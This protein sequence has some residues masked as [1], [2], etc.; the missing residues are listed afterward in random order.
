[1][2][3]FESTGNIYINTYANISQVSFTCSIFKLMETTE[4]DKEA[5][6]SHSLV[7]FFIHNFGQ[8]NV[9]REYVVVCIISF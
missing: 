5:V 1:M 9:N 8:V 4:Q 7:K 2:D 6:Q 3:G